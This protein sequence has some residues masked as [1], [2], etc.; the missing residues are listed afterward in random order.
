MFYVS[1]SPCLLS[2]ANQHT[3]LLVAI[4]VTQMWTIIELGI[5][6]LAG[7]AASLRPLLR[8]LN[9]TGLGSSDPRYGRSETFDGRSGSRFDPQ[10][11]GY[12]KQKNI[13]TQSATTEVV[14]TGQVNDSQELILE[15]GQKIH[16]R[17]DVTVSRTK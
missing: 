15:E 5:G 17:V 11:L 4:C 9:I 8:K 6:M 13:N 10:E 2:V 3:N 7:S 16:K 14:A 1:I 12:I